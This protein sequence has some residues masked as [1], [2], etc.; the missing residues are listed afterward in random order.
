MRWVSERM[1]RNATYTTFLFLETPVSGTMHSQST[2][3]DVRGRATCNL[4]WVPGTTLAAAPSTPAACKSDFS[5]TATYKRATSISYGSDSTVG[6]NLF[7]QDTTPDWINVVSTPGWVNATGKYSYT[8]KYLDAAGTELYTRDAF[9]N[10][11]QT[12]R[13]ILGRAT[14]AIRYGGLPNNSVPKVS[15]VTFYD[16]RGRV[17]RE[18]DDASGTH[19]YTYLP[20][21]E[22]ITTERVP[23]GAASGNALGSFERITI[24]NLGRPVRH[25][26]SKLMPPTSG[27]ACTSVTEVI[28]E[29]IKLFYDLPYA[30]GTSSYAFVAGKLAYQTNGIST[31]AYGYAMDGQVSQRDEWVNGIIDPQTGGAAAHTVA[32]SYRNDGQPVTTSITSITLP[33]T[34]S[35]TQSYDSVGRTAQIAGRSTFPPPATTEPRFWDTPATNTTAGAYDALGRRPIE[36]AD[37]G[38]L[39]MTRGYG[40]FSNQLVTHKIAPPTGNPFW[41]VSGMS[42]AANKL[43]AYTLKSAFEVAS[44][45]TYSTATGT[46]YQVK[47]DGDGRAGWARATPGSTPGTTTQNY[48]ETFNFLFDATGP[49]LWNLQGVQSGRLDATGNVTGVVSTQYEYH[50]DS[51]DRVVQLTRSDATSPDTFAYDG[52]GRGLIIAHATATAKNPPLEQF[53][54]DS[55][56]RLTRITVQG[57]KLEE[58]HYDAEGLL[59]T[60]SFFNGASGTDTARY[61]V[62]SDLS[63]VQ[64]GTATLAY[65]HVI[66]AKRRVASLYYASPA[67]SGQAFY[68]HRD[69]L[70]SVVG[71][72]TAGGVPGIAYRYDLYGKQTNAAGTATDANSSEIGYA[73]ALKLSDGLLHLKARQYSPSLRKF[74]QPDTVDSLRYTYVKGDPANSIDPTGRA[75][76][77]VLG[78]VGVTLCGKRSLRSCNCWGGRSHCSGNGRGRCYVSVRSRC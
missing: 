66:N 70:G 71:M 28:D 2:G 11:T 51:R 53:N 17:A 35:Y 63:V 32:R 60:R 54:Y 37:N 45:A 31:V 30:G 50:P 44:T 22:R 77:A 57:V 41:D 7:T 68:Y 56:G 49:S 52:R 4:Y 59:V 20:T 27:T 1:R 61:Y 62:D 9:G 6:R 10:F 26:Y 24:A 33:G 55:L 76:G 39:T 40:A 74:L 46:S 8:R 64:R 5:E 3:Y 36:L 69:R 75:V 29:D 78:V 14:K 58:L 15:F 16:Q 13:D 23:L 43:T 47:Y 72:S 34:V 25:Q 48:D 38:A 19:Y 65:V 73:G 18:D 67:A 42:Y 21:G 12:F